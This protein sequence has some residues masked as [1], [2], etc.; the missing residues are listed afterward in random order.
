MIIL[1]DGELLLVAG[2]HGI[3]DITRYMGTLKTY[4]AHSIISRTKKDLFITIKNRGC[5]L[6]IQKMGE[7][8]INVKVCTSSISGGYYEYTFVNDQDHFLYN[9][10][11]GQS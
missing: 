11:F 7:L 10:K 5:E 9:L 4:Q 1:D 3:S 8:G 2:A 6:F